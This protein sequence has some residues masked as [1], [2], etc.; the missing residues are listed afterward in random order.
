MSRKSAYV[1]KA[2]DPAFAAAWAEASKAASRRW[3]QGDKVDEM[4]GPPIPSI[5]V[6]T[7]PSPVERKHDFVRLLAAIRES[8]PLAARAPAQ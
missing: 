7:S 6:H 3:L 5:E 2:R 1:L 4:D 8:P